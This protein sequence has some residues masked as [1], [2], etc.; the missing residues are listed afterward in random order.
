VGRTFVGG[1]SLVA[2]VGG[3]GQ[4]RLGSDEPVRQLRDLAGEL[5]DDAVLLFDVALQ[6]SEAFLEGALVIIHVGKME[7][8][9]GRAR[10]Y[11]NS[12]SGWPGSRFGG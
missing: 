3:L 11:D 6:E 9:P 10:R 5:E 8:D 2:G 12:D 1:R 4:L 7:A